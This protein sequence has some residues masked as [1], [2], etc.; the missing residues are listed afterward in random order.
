MHDIGL[1]ELVNRLADDFLS[2]IA[3][4]REH[5]IVE[6]RDDPVSVTQ[7]DNAVRAVAEHFLEFLFGFDQRRLGGDAFGN[8]AA[9]AQDTQG[10]VD[11]DVT[12]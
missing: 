2:R 11:I 3:A 10:V 1:R 12:Q 4:A 7:D 5:G 6:I 8:V 9:D